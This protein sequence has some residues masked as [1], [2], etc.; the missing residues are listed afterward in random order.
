MRRLNFKLP[1]IPQLPKW[2]RVDPRFLRFNNGGLRVLSVMIAIALWVFVNAGER[3]SVMSL[4]V[5]ISYRSLPAG[6][7]I[8]NQPPDFVTIEV[9]GPRTL[10]SLLEPERLSLRLDLRGVVPGQS[11]IK[12]YPGMFNVP[13]QT[14][15]NRI[16]PDQLSLDIDRVISRSVPIK[17]ALD[18]KVADGYK[19]ASIE[20][21]P[22]TVSISGPS[23]YVSQL[24]QVET[25]P[26]DVRGLNA[27][28]ERS[29][30]L[31]EWNPAVRYSLASVEAF[32]DIGEE[33]ADREFKGVAVEVKDPDYK[34]RVDPKRATLTIRGP[35][36]KLSSLDAKGIA[37]VDAKDLM[38]GSHELPLQVTLPDGMEL[39][40][41]SPD[42]VRLRIY[43]ERRTITADEQNPS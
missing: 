34:Y 9:A 36:L 19:V 31:A 41:Q 28:I 35:T 8:M 26:C 13:R 10:L 6:M 1:Q 14:S 12:L 38:P 17:L 7:A 27:D 5:P 32:V 37:Y 30:A 22:A 43:R 42:K 3:G 4:T 18:G 15:V 11:D 25:Q 21:R 40:R 39:V 24:N 23:R 16:S 2:L 29:I 33:I 20:L